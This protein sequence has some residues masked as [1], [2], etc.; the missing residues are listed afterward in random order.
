MRS[1]EASDDYFSIVTR[2]QGDSFADDFYLGTELQQAYGDIYTTGASMVVG[3]MLSLQTWAH[4]AF[5]WDGSQMFAYL[6]MQ[7]TGPAP[8]SGQLDDSGGPIYLGADRNNYDEMTPAGVPDLNFVD[9]SLDEV[10]IENVA[11]SPAWLAYDLA[12]QQDAIISYGP[13][14]R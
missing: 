14:V 7:A 10:R 3:A 11:R 2:E 5:T 9:G 12:S 13:V 8:A 4:L 6:G 1:A